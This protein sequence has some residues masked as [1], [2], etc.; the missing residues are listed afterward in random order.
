MKAPLL[1]T[2]S[3]LALAPLSSLRAQDPMPVG[4]PLRDYLNQFETQPGEQLISSQVD[5]NGDGKDEVF[6][7][8]SSLSNGRQ[9]NIWV[10]YESLPDGTWKRHDGLGGDGGGVIEFHLKAVSV[11]PDG[12]GGKMLVRYSPGSATSG[13]LTTFQLRKGAVLETTRQGEINPRDGDAALYDQ[14]FAK[15]ESQLTFQLRDMTELRAKYLPFN[16]W[17]REIT[18][19]KLIFL[20][21]CVFA[22]VWLLRDFLRLLG[23]NKRRL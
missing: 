11:Q 3:A 9:G 13:R 8:R 1:L 18:A 4:D 21:L 12:K 20:A 16:G 14:Y 17:F 5:L 2:A 6:L 7:S 10:L 23:G 22:P 19:G 15:P